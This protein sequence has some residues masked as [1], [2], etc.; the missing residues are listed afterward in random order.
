MNRRGYETGNRPFRSGCEHDRLVSI[1]DGPHLD[2]IPHGPGQNPALDVTSL[3]DQVLRAVGVRDALHV[4]FNDRTFIKIA[5]HVMC[6][7][8]NQLYAPVPCLMVGTRPFKPGRN[9]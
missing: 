7:R 2:V 5:G 1:E 9:E 4:L 3:A 8:T 6:C